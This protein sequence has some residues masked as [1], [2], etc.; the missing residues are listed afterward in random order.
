MRTSDRNG[1][2]RPCSGGGGFSLV[3]VVIAV[4]IF[5]AA[6]TATLA[7]LPALAR[8]AA[9]SEDT[10]NA[11]RL[12][13]AVETELRRVAVA[14]GFDAL[15]ARTVPLAAPL[16]ETFALVASRDTSRLHAQ[17]YLAPPASGQLR[18]DEQYF[19]VEAWRFDEAP[20]AFDPAGAWLALHVRVSWPYH[21]PGSASTTP[22]AARSRLT[23]NLGLSR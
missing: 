18:E 15:A 23:F 9:V 5:A 1:R 6:V 13:G 14:G 8:R 22:L 17:S 20:L 12:P 4:G 2:Q 21:V 3:E 19:L 7:L 11:A 16:P 10:L